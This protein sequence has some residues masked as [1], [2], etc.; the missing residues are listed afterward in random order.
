MNNGVLNYIRK[1]SKMNKSGLRS[2]MDITQDSG[3]CDGGSI[4][5]GD[6]NLNFF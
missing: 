3:S 6:I 4:P 5:S 2:V 1:N